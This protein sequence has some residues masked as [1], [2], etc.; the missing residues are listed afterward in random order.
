[1][2]CFLGLILLAAACGSPSNPGGYDDDTQPDAAHAL[3]PNQCAAFAQSAATAASTCGT[4][5]PAGGQASIE[6]WCRKG[7]TVAA[8]CGNNPAEGHTSNTTPKPSDKENQAGQ[9]Y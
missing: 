2:N 4:P 1:M 7:V 8:A 6:Q 5:L 3:D 9:P